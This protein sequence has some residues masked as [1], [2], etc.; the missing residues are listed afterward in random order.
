LLV[1]TSSFKQA[2]GLR[3]STP[4]L[5]TETAASTSELVEGGLE[6]QAF[7][8]AACE[9]HPPSCAAL[10]PSRQSDMAPPRRI[11]TVQLLAAWL[12]FLAVF[13]AVAFAR[14]L[15]EP[16]ASVSP[17]FLA[18]SSAALDGSFK[19]LFGAFLALLVIVRVSAAFDI[20]NLTAWR[21]TA[22]VHVIEAGYFAQAAFLSPEGVFGPRGPRK[23]PATAVLVFASIVLNAVI[24]T[25]WWFWLRV[26]E[27]RELAAAAAS[28]SAGGASG[29]GA[30]GGAAGAA[31]AAGKSFASPTAS[32]QAARAAASAVAQAH[33]QAQAQAH[34]NQHLESEDE[35]AHEEDREADDSDNAEDDETDEDFDAATAAA[36]A[37]A[38][39]GAGAARLR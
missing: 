2:K 29:G 34:A 20:R 35:D 38:A 3:A 28:G 4:R 27:R 9:N 17:I 12:L 24:F 26:R 16:L 5:P 7:R 14:L 31:G 10:D 8:R 15:T 32:E 22:I 37:A 18:G 11:T 19:K 30:A 13:D 23:P 25:C 6:S 33:A 1:G 36:D 21:I 39:S